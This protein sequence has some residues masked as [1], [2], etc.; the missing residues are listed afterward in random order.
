ME[1]DHV[2]QPNPNL[3]V[4]YI[5][6]MANLPNHILLGSINGDVHIVQSSCLEYEE[7]L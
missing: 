6:T 1:K 7:M 3:L 5:S 2:A 4:P